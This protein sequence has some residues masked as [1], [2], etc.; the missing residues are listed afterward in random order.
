[1][2]ILV[3]GNGFDIAH[4]LPTQYKDFLDFMK[5][6]EI[7]SLEKETYKKWKVFI[8]ELEEQLKHN[9]DEKVKKFFNDDKFLKRSSFSK[10]KN[11]DENLKELINCTENNI[12]LKYFSNNRNYIDKRWVDF[13]AE[14]SKVV[15]CI[16][17]GKDISVYYWRYGNL[18]KYMDR[19]NNKEKIWEQ[20]ISLSNI[21]STIKI[22]DKYP[23][24]I[25]DVKE[26]IERLNNDLIQITRCLEIYLCSYVGAIQLTE[27]GTISELYD[28]EFDEVLSFNYT[29]TFEKGKY[30]LKPIYQKPNISSISYSNQIDYIHGKADLEKHKSKKEN[31]MVLGI[32]EYLSEEDKNKKLDFI[33]FKKYFQRIYKKTGNEYKKWIKNMNETTPGYDK[34]VPIF[35][36]CIYIFGHSLDES[37][38]DILKQLI[39]ESGLKKKDGSYVKNTQII[40][41][42]HNKDAYT[43]QIINLVKIIGQDELIERVSS[44]HPSIVFIGQD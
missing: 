44:E 8:D 6:I 9:V 31:N 32:D 30:K 40:I 34:S 38:K 16:D 42:Y 2:E 3:I 10:W 12:W 14:I 43:Q 4:G 39:L 5:G 17:Y 19:D 21:Y 26:I 24:I 35:D 27:E 25:K 1:M 11:D 41:Y 23:R 20:I 22:S 28:K 7:I 15:Q 36:N 18:D 29:N 33:Q 37:D 13:E